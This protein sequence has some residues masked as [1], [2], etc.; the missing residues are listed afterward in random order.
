MHFHQHHEPFLSSATSTAGNGHAAMAKM[1]SRVLSR[2]RLKLPT[3]HCCQPKVKA[4]ITSVS[5]ARKL[6]VHF[7]PSWPQP[8]RTDCA[9]FLSLFFLFVCFFKKRSF[10]CVPLQ[11]QMRQCHPV[12]HQ[13]NIWPKL[14]CALLHCGQ[15]AEKPLV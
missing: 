7:S 14:V 2:A 3:S 9:V 6:P 10:I 8:V 13:H 15:N 4:S 1:P 12:F 11:L 5:L